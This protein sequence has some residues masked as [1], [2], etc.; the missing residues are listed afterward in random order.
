[1]PYRLVPRFLLRAP[2]LPVRERTRRARAILDHPLGRDALAVASPALL[3]AL[4][5]GERPPALDRYARRAAFRPTP[6]GLWA[7]VAV[8]RL[9]ART[10]I[11]TGV[12][13]AHLTLR[14]SY[15]FAL[16]RSLLERAEIRAQVRLRRAPSL[17]WRADTARWLTHGEGADARAVTAEVD[18]TLARVL[19]ATADWRRWDAV[20]DCNDPEATEFALLLVDDGL[21]H[22]DLTPPLVGPPPLAWMID[23][24]RRLVPQPSEAEDLE[25]IREALESGRIDAA[26]EGAAHATLVF[27]PRGAP[28]L[29]AAA[30]RRAVALAP[31]LFR[32]QDALA[33]P[34]AERAL[35][36]G[37]ADALD[38]VT[39]VFGAGAFDLGALEVGDYGTPLGA[40]DDT[41][42]PPAPPPPP[43]TRLLVDRF[44]AAVAAGDDEVRLEA[45]ELEEVLPPLEPPAT[46]ELLLTPC[47]E[48]RGRP[49]GT[50]WLLGLH[51]PAG[52]TWGRFLHALGGDLGAALAETEAAARPDERRLD[53]VYA[54]SVELAD[55]AA[56]PPLRGSALALTSWP[57]NEAVT[58]NELALVVDPAER[59][60]ALA[61]LSGKE[62]V[63]SPLV[64]VRSTTAPPGAF[65]LLVGFSLW[66]QHA[67]WVATLGPLAGLERTPRLS[68]D[69]FVIAPASWRLPAGELTPADLRRWRARLGVPREVQVG[70]E[71]ELLPVDL[72]DAGAAAELAR[73]GATRVYEIWPP[74]DRLVDADGRRVEVV[75]GVVEETAAA[76]APRGLAQA[77]MRAPRARPAPRQEA[78]GRQDASSNNDIRRGPVT[79][80]PPPSEA[81]PAAGWRTYKLFGA[82]DR[83]DRVLSTVVA[84]VVRAASERGEIDRWFFL[85]YVDGPGRRDHL[86]LRVHA[87]GS[88][89]PFEARLEAALAPARAACDVVAVE[90]AEYRPEYARFGGAEATRA[91][92]EVFASE[93]EL[94]LDLV[95]GDATVDAV[96]IVVRAWDSLARVAGLDESAVATLARRVR[97]ASAPDLP[98]SEDELAQD[99]RRRHARLVA[100]LAGTAR[101]EATAPLEAH[102]ARLWQIRGLREAAERAAFLPTLLH[103][104][105]VR[106]A[107]P[108]RAVEA[109]AAYVWDRVLVGVSRMRGR[110]R[111]S[112]P[113]RRS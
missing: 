87:D 84:P 81:P 75:V 4:S 48:P 35:D 15:L 80:V 56:H 45:A 72:E 107:G 101:D 109:H 102:A 62:I 68:V 44:L 60:L 111:S 41:A 50:G 112:P 64:R 37:V 27:E 105:A 61:T 59:A 43:L 73:L 8:G 92:E 38:A 6:H 7:G 66:R 29:S 40:E 90:M 21:L 20:F 94:V 2:L 31:L 99:Y 57:E 19:E 36:P 88:F 34:A 85:R 54:P 11:Q 86:R 26:P 95:A 10:A 74:L 96:E 1:M 97:R 58:P 9:G 39:E 93:S 63:P 104:G 46:F 17:I 53:V 23:R 16:G 76:C 65:R 47:R 42:A 24:L 18:D 30:V 5:R 14:W 70:E 106:I 25:A 98:A 78:C 28:T 49:P 12:P 3:A 110:L 51:A 79:R 89:S 91:A 22:T 55:V 82:A 108:D 83:Q 67:P 52:A 32:L 71:D 69:G 103:L 33:H 100:L 77:A 113:D 13:R